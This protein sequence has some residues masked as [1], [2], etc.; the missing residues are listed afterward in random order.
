MREELINAQTDKAGRHRFSNRR[1]TLLY[2]VHRAQSHD[3]TNKRLQ[4]LF[5]RYIAE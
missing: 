5:P 1:V 2:R 4:L 3:N